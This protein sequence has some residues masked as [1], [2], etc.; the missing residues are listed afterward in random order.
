MPPTIARRC[1]H[2]LVLLA[3]M[4]FCIACLSVFAQES[5]EGEENKPRLPFE[6]R[7]VQI[8]FTDGSTLRLHLADEQIEM[9]S[10]HGKLQI[11]AEDILRIEFALRLPEETAKQIDDLMTQLR[12]PDEDIRDT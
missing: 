2:S 5:E 7:A 1:V 11:P 10:P 8:T 6:P 3:S 4:A 12:S 9:T